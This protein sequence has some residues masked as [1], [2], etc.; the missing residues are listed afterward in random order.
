M[1][2]DPDKIQRIRRT[3]E[4]AGFYLLSRPIGGHLSSRLTT[5][6]GVIGFNEHSFPVSRCRDR[7][8]D[9]L[10][11]CSFDCEILHHTLLSL[12]APLRGSFYVTNSPELSLI[13]QARVHKCSVHARILRTVRAVINPGLNFRTLSIS[14]C[15]SPTARYESVWREFQLRTCTSASFHSFSCIPRKTSLRL[16]SFPAAKR[17]SVYRT[18]NYAENP[19]KKF[20]FYLD[21]VEVDYVSGGRGTSLAKLSI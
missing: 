10:A 20:L 13:A 4:T 8:R 16:C 17:K 6:L 11:P 18:S 9:C 1:H 2:L 19:W 5:K 15:R 7:S 3:V 12:P 21:R 14:R